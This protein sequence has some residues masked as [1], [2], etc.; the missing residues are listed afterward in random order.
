M[1]CGEF[2]R[3]ALGR[4]CDDA[5]A[6]AWAREAEAFEHVAACGACMEE[7]LEL[8]DIVDALR[9]AGRALRRRRAR[10]N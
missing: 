5:D 4:I 8:A 2:R 7:W 9:E 6:G 3:E 1:T 10:S